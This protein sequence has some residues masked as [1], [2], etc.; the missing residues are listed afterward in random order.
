MK[1]PGL[2]AERFRSETSCCPRDRREAL[3]PVVRADREVGPQALQSYV[4]DV[5]RLGRMFSL[6]LS[7]LQGMKNA[8]VH[9]SQTL[10]K[11]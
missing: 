4:L 2:A 8:E 3:Y 11:P 6:M 10:K 9:K 7:G 5:Y 1:G